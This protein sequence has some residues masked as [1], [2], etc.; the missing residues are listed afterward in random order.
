MGLVAQGGKLRDRM[1]FPDG[2]LDWMSA[3]DLAFY[4]GEFARAGFTG[5]LNR[6]RCV[7]LDWADLRAWH[8]VPLRQPSLFIG[9]ERDGPTLWGAGSIARYPQ[10]LPNL[11]A[12]VILPGVG[13]WMQQE[14]AAGV[15]AAL[16]G[17]L[18][19]LP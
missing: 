14:D 9:G 11:H 6:Y 18:A 19:S 8:G 2:P 12:S 7:D 15:N 3:N 4:V 17:F 5:G 10:T 16:L 1:R 13:H